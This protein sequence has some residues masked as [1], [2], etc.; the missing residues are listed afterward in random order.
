MRKI[1]LDVLIKESTLAEALKDA[2]QVQWNLLI[3][4]LE[5][6]DT[7][8]IWTPSYGLKWCFII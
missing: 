6:V 8:I 4:T 5:N 1:I 3:K 2:L 7:C